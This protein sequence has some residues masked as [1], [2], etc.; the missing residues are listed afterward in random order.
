V[1]IPQN[2]RYTESHEWAEDLGGGKARVGLT[3]HAQQSMGDIVFVNLPEAGDDVTAGERLADVESVKAAS[4]VYSP[5]SGK[6]SAINEA[7]LGDPAA[8]N[9]NA[10]D[11][12]LVELS[13][14]GDS[15]T[16][17]SAEEYE[18]LVG[19]A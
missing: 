19:E 18:A 17:L 10:Y 2:L 11:A 15:V 1:N 13:D 16:L 14:T 5:L 4:D 6:V 9:S 8:I 12:W 3:D 7:L